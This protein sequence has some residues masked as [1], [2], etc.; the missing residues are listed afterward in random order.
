MARERPFVI[1]LLAIL[2]LLGAAQALIVT[3][4]MLHLLPIYVGQLHFWT[5]DFWGALLWGILFLIYLWVFRMLW[6]VDP[7]G[8]LFLVI[9]SGLNLILAFLAI[10]GGSTWDAMSLAIIINGLILIYCLLP[11]TKRAF[12]LPG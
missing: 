10:L 5:F 4:Q 11:S 8:W 12:E 2:A 3:L 6:N 1:T 9:I 7:Q